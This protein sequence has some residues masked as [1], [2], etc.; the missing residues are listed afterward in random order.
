M[1]KSWDEMTYREKL[2]MLR[3]DIFRIHASIGS[4]KRDQ[5]ETWEALRATRSEIGKIAKDVGT[6]KALWPYSQ[7]KYSRTG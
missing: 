5:D 3:Q 4:L 7:K 6:L 1:A 2:E